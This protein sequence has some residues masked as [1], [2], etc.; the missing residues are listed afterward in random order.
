MARGT[1]RIYLGAAPGVGKTYAMLNEGRRRK[2]RGTDVVVAY[3]EDHGRAN[4]A[5][6]IG[7]LEVMA[8]RELAHKGV[9]LEEMDVDAVLARRPAVA[10]VDELAHTNAPG[11]RNE[12][13]WQDVEELV[14]AG[15]HVI[16]TVNVQHLES[17]NDVLAEI[18][19]IRQQETLPDAEV[20]KADQ[21]EIVDMSPEAL[22]RRMAHGNIYTPEKVDAA[23]ANY[24]RPGNL[25]A[26]REMALLWVADRVDEQLDRYRETFGITKSWE[27]RERIV[28]AMTGAPHG[29]ML[30]RRAARIAER[31]RGDLIGVHVDP[32][33]GRARADDDGLARL[34][35]LVIELGGTY[36]EVVGSDVPA[37][38]VQFARSMN[39]TQI[40][41]GETGRSR[42]AEIVRGSVINRVVRASAP[43]DVHVIGRRDDTPE[44][45]PRRPRRRRHPTVLSP[46]RRVAGWLLFAAGVPLLTFLLSLFHNHTALTTDVLLYLLLV[47]SVAVVGGLWPAITTAVVGFLCLNWYFTP[48]LHSWTIQ[49]AENVFSLVVFV[50]VGA[51]V[52]A[53]VSLS[54]RRRVEAERAA[55]AAEALAGVSGDV[56]AAAD[57]FPRFVSHVCKTFGRDC[58]AL[59][60]RVDGA[61]RCEASDG[62]PVPSDPDAADMRVDVGE[63]WSLCLMGGPLSMHDRRVLSAFCAQLTLAVVNRH[64]AEEATRAGI[65]E[66][67]DKLRVSLLNAVSHDLRT[68]LASIKT[69]A[70]S[71]RQTDVE[72]PEAARDEFLATIDDQSDRL[73]RI[74]GNLL[75]MS[76]I[77]A[78]AVTVLR[79][80]VGI[81]DVVAAAVEATGAPRGRLDV[82][83][84][85]DLPN[86]EVDPALVE[87]AL[88]NV[89]ANALAWAPPDEPVRLE[90]AAASG[91]VHVRIVDRG[92]GID[93]SD[94]DRVFQPFQRLG[95]SPN[96]SG[97]GLGM[98]VAKGFVEAVGG[99]LDL[100]DTPGGGLTVVMSF[101][102]MP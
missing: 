26:L 29:D 56:L 30:V 6:Q 86:V 94:R 37:A 23:L 59:L 84:A 89:V 40:V 97:V 11:S 50:G 80:P 21:I 100:E 14:D 20:R 17:L 2:S 67:T 57:P 44:T 64:L 9:V 88:A 92:P 66:E 48:P 24:F 19:G 69:A 18:T 42:L 35:R 4:T 60:H 76:R 98:A 61:W 70:T 81:D 43:I 38:I 25:A 58:V 28:V 87:R 1:L 41:L 63:D 22:R 91:R 7:D 31:A 13:R 46:R 34:S 33:D 45:R 93:A 75:D 77:Q 72:L 49:E 74:V 62:A 55:A 90:A 5:A 99:E 101:E 73:N 47:I 52:S 78:G 96:G 36:H 54:V 83:V 16:T 3:V 68:P 102:A 95:D 39:A 12:K 51:G 71:L 10:L 65:L 53:L 79:R 8:R 85:A 27:T 32:G 82:T 15:I